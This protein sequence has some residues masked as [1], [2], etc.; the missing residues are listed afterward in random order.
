MDRELGDQLPRLGVR[1]E[2]GMV[3]MDRQGHSSKRVV[4]PRL[5]GPGSDQIAAPENVHRDL[6]P[7]AQLHDHPGSA[8]MVAQQVVQVLVGV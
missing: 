3:S 8:A 5:W 7:L 4:V 2:V 1:I 6:V